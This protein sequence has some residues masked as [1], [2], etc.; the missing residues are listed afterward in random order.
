M[1][2]RKEIYDSGIFNI[3]RESDSTW[4]P[5]D[6]DNKDYQAVLAYC[7]ENNITIDDLPIYEG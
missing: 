4:I 7:T 5:P 2:S 3:Y 1:Y 6:Q